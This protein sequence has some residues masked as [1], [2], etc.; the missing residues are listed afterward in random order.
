MEWIN[1][2]DRLPKMMGDGIAKRSEYVAV[3]TDNKYPEIAILE[4]FDGIAEWYFP[5]N[6][7]SDNFNSVTHW[8]EIP[9]F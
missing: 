7:E 2:K 5:V 1:V 9:K 6:D 3:K 8:C 4:E